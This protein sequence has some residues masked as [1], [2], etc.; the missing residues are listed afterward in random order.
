MSKAARRS[1]VNT[2][3]SAPRRKR[4][5]FCETCRVRKTRC[6]VREQGQLRCVLCSLHNWPCTF[7]RGPTS[8]QHGTAVDG[9]GTGSHNAETSEYSSFLRRT[10][11]SDCL[12]DV[13]GSGA[14]DVPCL[15]VSA[16]DG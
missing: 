12:E 14:E 6:V 8:R 10:S 11:F 7:L 2:L 5:R 4:S 15:G 9:G 16:E 13:S 1:Q 3:T